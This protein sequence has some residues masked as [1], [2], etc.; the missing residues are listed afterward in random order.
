M[1]NEYENFN[2]NSS[3]NNNNSFDELTKRLLEQQSK[4]MELSNN[5]SNQGKLLNENSMKMK[6]L[7]SEK[8][9]LQSTLDA[10]QNQLNET[11]QY[12][13][14]YQELLAKQE[15]EDKM[16]IISLFKENGVGQE[17]V[18]TALQGIKSTFNVDLISN[19]NLNTADAL[20]KQYISKNP[21]ISQQSTPYTIPNNGNYN[22]NMSN[23]FVQQPQKMYNS[24]EEEM[25]DF[26]SDE[27]KEELDKKIKNYTTK[28]GMFL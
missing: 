27:Q 25:Y 22:M 13:Q 17:Y 11:N 12:K 5:L 2:G 28:H 18:E 6:T 9:Q 20:I 14:M 26:L 19:K 15:Q 7:E 24:V 4:N 1:N 3:N 16:K 23:N 21:N 10:L 8:Q